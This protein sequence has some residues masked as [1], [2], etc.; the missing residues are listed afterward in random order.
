MTLDHSSPHRIL[1]DADPINYPELCICK[2]SNGNNEELEYFGLKVF[3]GDDAQDNMCLLPKDYIRLSHNLFCLLE[4]N[5][6]KVNYMNGKPMLYVICT[7][8]TTN[9]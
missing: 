2:C 1:N 4:E 6:W 7:S 8:A 9:I 3:D 5:N